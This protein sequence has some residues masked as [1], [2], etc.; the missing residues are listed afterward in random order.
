M[1]KYFTFDTTNYMESINN[2]AKFFDNMPLTLL[3]DA[4]L[5]GMLI[6]TCSYSNVK[7]VDLITECLQLLGYS[8]IR[9]VDTDG[10]YIS[11]IIDK[12]NIRIA[13]NHVEVW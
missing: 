9:N 1:K 10:I 7:Q 5:L 2:M 11:M 4:N 3:A 8:V 6:I 13:N 12:W